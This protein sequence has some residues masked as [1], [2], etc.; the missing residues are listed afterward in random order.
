M[1]SHDRLLNIVIIEDNDD[2]RESIV[3]ALSGYGHQVHGV[4]SAE[5]LHEEPSLAQVD[6]FIIDINLP[7][8]NG[9]SLSSRLRSCQPSVG[10]IMLTAQAQSEDRASGYQHGAD[11]YLTKPASLDELYSAIRSLS[12]RLTITSD[13]NGLV[14]DCRQLECRNTAT[15]QSVR[16]THTDVL[17]LTAFVRAPQQRLE[18]FMIGECL[19]LDMDTS[20]KTAIEVY[21]SRLRSKLNLIAPDASPFKAIRGWG[22]QF[23]LTLSLI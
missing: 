10:I 8:E 12:R 4:E 3:D 22:Y 20:S 14:L 11:I 23:T 5:A 9:L 15:Q 18:T 21:I 7:G 19:G 17:L 2:L 1:D 6:L 13:K 16:L